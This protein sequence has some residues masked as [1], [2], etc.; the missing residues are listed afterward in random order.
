MCNIRG[1]RVS[2]ATHMTRHTA[3][4]EIQNKLRK[5]SERLPAHMIRK[6]V[7]SMTTNAVFVHSWS[8]T[9]VYIETSQVM[10]TLDE[11][12]SN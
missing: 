5:H 2:I 8:A 12:C 4:R 6:K 10:V 9:C 3:P 11:C 1:F 7:Y